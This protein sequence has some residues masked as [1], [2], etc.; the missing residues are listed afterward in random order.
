[1]SLPALVFS[2]EG[3]RRKALTPGAA[4]SQ[5]YISDFCTAVILIKLFMRSADINSEEARGDQ[6]SL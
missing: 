1:M 5:N 3:N 4:R 2:L 6:I